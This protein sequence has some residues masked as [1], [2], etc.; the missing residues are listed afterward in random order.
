M[1]FGTH[2]VFYGTKLGHKWKWGSHTNTQKEDT[3]AGTS[4]ENAFKKSSQAASKSTNREIQ[5]IQ[6]EC[7][8]MLMM[9]C[10]H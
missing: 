10:I 6:E 8:L 2:L 9:I 5:D 1:T 7:G 4:T 3:L